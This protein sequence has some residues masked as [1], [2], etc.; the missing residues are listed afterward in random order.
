V[1]ALE[2]YFSRGKETKIVLKQNGICGV[3]IPNRYNYNK[4]A[5]IRKI[6]VVLSWGAASRKIADQFCDQLYTV[7]VMQTHK[8]HYEDTKCLKITYDLIIN[9]K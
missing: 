2:I 1:F 5:L 6:N 3:S 4:G 8:E 7:F 9:S